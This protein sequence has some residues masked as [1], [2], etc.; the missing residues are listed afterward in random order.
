M[1]QQCLQAM[2]F[3]PRRICR[4]RVPYRHYAQCGITSHDADN[5][6]WH[7]AFQISGGKNTERCAERRSDA[8]AC[9]SR[10]CFKSAA[11]LTTLCWDF[12]QESRCRESAPTCC[13]SDAKHPGDSV[14][15]AASFIND[16]VARIDVQKFADGHQT[17]GWHFAGRFCHCLRFHCAA[18]RCPSVQRRFQISR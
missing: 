15:F 17:T 13:N 7:G 3:K 5:M 4:S 9:L 18:R 16:T 11:T 1:P 10:H 8:P 14:L 6:A 12:I 2:L